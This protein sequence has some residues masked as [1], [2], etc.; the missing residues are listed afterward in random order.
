VNIIATPAS[1]YRFVDWTGNVGTVGN[2]NSASTNIIMNDDYTIT[3]TFAVIQTGGGDGGLGGGGGGGGSGGVNGKTIT[4]LRGSSSSTGVVW[5]NI[6]AVS[7]DTK[8]TLDIPYGTR[9]TNANGNALSSITITEIAEPDDAQNGVTILGTVYEFGPKGANFSPLI[10]LTIEYN[11]DNL[12]P[13]IPESALSIAIWDT[14]SKTYK[15]VDCRVNTDTNKITASISHFSR[16]TII[17]APRP[18]AFTLSNLSVS[19]ANVKAGDTVNISVTVSNTGD[20]SGDYT[21]SVS[22]NGV[23]KASKK[24]TVS[25]NSQTSVSLSI[26]AEGRGQCTV[27]V[28]S[29]SGSFS[30]ITSPA[31]FEASALIISP[32]EV[33]IGGK[34]TV[35]VTVTNKGE[36]A[37]TYQVKLNI[38]GKAADTK[39]VS[40]SGGESRQASFTVTGI[41]AGKATIE[42]NGLTG[43]LIVLAAKPI[44]T[45]KTQPASTTPAVTTPAQVTTSSQVTPRAGTNWGL[46][47]GIIASGVVVAAGC[48]LYFAWWRRR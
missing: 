2:T 22:V 13:T 3:A 18:A 5:A 44:Q 9:C 35:S 8:T 6:Q 46:I 24:V 20:V 41:T 48:V 27:N 29:L 42:V 43:S 17:T 14:E 39:E 23:T 38:D 7:M 30:I 4:S 19:P 37:G 32:A 11:E 47:A 36:T 12:P 15:R 45:Q 16:Y 40:L 26:T 28:G 21:C 1:G 31:S 25:A 10:I 34:A 33:D